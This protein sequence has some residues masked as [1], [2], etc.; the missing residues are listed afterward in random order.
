MRLGT[1]RAVR[2]EE[3]VAAGAVYRRV[4][5]GRL[6]NTARVLELSR[7]Q[8]GI[9][10]VRFSVHYERPDSCDELRTLAVTVFRQVFSELIAA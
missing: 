1:V 7:D 6:V 10:H 8:A 2:N 5:D 9:L 3:V 4:I